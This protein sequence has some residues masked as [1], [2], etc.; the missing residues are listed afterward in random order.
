MARAED[1]PVKVALERGLV[2]RCPTCGILHAG[3]RFLHVDH[4]MY[5]SSSCFQNREER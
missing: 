3:I 5:C 4:R 1:L 2:V